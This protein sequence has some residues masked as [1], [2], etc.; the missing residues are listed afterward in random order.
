MITIYIA[1]I[2]AVLIL[3]V[4]S[5]KQ[6]SGYEITGYT[7]ESDRIG[8]KSVRFVMLSDLHDTDVTHDLNARLLDSIDKLSPDFVILAGDMITSYM[9]SSYNSDITFSFLRDLSSRHTVYYGVGNHEQRYKAEPEKF[10]GKY[11]ELVSFVKSCGIHF[12]SDDS[13]DVPGTNI[14]ILGF[15]IPIENYKRGVRSHLPE[16]K[17]SDTFGE[18]DRSKYNI[19]IAHTPDHFEDY[20]KYGP[21]LVLSGH[22]HGGIIALPGVGGVISPQLRLFPKYDRGLFQINDTR[23]VVSRGIGWHSLPIRL[24]N[25][26]EMVCIDIQPGN[27]D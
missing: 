17:L 18:V 21:D 25:R 24:F 15:D 6:S 20:A 13:E 2:A 4:F 22:L 3:A 5:Y 8:S 27:K 12:L 23:M 1:I 9:Q 7:F 26:A 11:D 14:R 16:G 10:P 19:L